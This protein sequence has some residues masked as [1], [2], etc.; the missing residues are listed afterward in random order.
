MKRTV[1]VAAIAVLAAAVA[2]VFLVRRDDDAPAS[3]ESGRAPA[4]TSSAR[5]PG[6]EAAARP[7]LPNATAVPPELAA[8]KH[9]RETVLGALRDSG[10]G[11]EPWD[12][13]GNGLLE[14]IAR[15]AS[16]WTQVG[17]FVAGCGATY[18]FA[19]ED[20][21][22]RGRAVAEALDEYH[23]WTGGKRWTAP[24]RWVDGRVSITLVLYRPD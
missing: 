18:L 12:D 3:S 6:S 19:S 22:T 9:E 14:K 8:A 13:Q 2:L 5:K 20:A 10:K 17:C 24:E 4:A 16:G 23:A 21:M 7:A 1:V 11:A 15:T